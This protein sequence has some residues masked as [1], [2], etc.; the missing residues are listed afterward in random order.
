MMKIVNDQR[1]L[2][3]VRK[4]RFPRFCRHLTWRDNA[5]GGGHDE[6]K[7]TEIYAGVQG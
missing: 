4:L 2:A 3:S 1:V 7:E 5:P 6:E